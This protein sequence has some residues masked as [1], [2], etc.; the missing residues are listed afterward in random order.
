MSKVRGASVYGA[1]VI[2]MAEGLKVGR[3]SEIYIDPTARKIIGISYKSSGLGT[4]KEIFVHFGDVLKF[5]SDVVIIADQAVGG[6]PPAEIEPF[7]LRAL[8]RNKITTQSGT[9]IAELADVVFDNADGKILEILLPQNL[10]LDIAIDRVIF[11]HD[12]VM[13][14]ADYEPATTRI[15]PEKKDFM[16]RIFRDMAFSEKF[17]EGY[18]EAKHSVRDNVTR[19]KVAQSLKTGSRKARDSILRTS[20]AIQQVLDQINKRRRTTKS[21][22]ETS[23]TGASAEP[24]DAEPGRS[25]SGANA[26]SGWDGT[27]PRDPQGTEKP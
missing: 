1:M 15:E 14:P 10:R 2:A 3:A 21:D 12:L 6:D 19:D 13:V 22:Q 7:G 20:R 8:R 24:A 17:R 18:A 11:G 9:H 4:D 26:V 25:D 16:D 27:T 23:G 5:S